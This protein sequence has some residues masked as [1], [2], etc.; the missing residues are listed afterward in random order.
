[1]AYVGEI[2]YFFLKENLEFTPNA[3]YC[4]IVCKKIVIL[5]YKS[6]FIS[7]YK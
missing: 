4:H 3:M 5:D 1:M 6:Y 2:G 7:I